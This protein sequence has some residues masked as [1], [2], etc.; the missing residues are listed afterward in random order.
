VYLYD[1][2]GS[3]RLSLLDTGQ[4]WGDTVPGTVTVGEDGCWELRLDLSTNHSATQRHCVEDGV[5]VEHAGTTFQRFDFVAAEVDEHQEFTCDPPPDTVRPDAAPGDAWPARCTGVSRA[6][7]TTVTSSGE[8]VFV[9]PEVLRIGGEDVDTLHYTRDR[10]LSGDQ[11]GDE[12]QD[13]WYDATTAMVVKFR[14]EVRVAS[15]SPLG[16]VVYT[17]SGTL[18]L[19]STDPVS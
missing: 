14:R 7:G 16:D 12:S 8:N 4:D 17:E 9:G 1:A 19:R 10:E 18:Q 6:R 13:V 2:E 15:P 3:E 11:V 5:L